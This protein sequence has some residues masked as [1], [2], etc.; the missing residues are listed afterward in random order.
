MERS[1]TGH[2][3]AAHPPGVLGLTRA[4]DLP[5]APVLATRDAGVTGMAFLELGSGEAASGV[6]AP[7]RDDAFLIALQ[8]RDCTDFDLYADGRLVRPR[9]FAAGNVAIFDLRENLAT[10]RRAAFH[11]VDLYLPQASL[12]AIAED[13]GAARIDDLRHDTG[14]AFRDAVARDLLSSIRPALALP[15]QANQLFLDHVALALASHV[16]HT[17]GG[18]RARPAT[19]PGALAPWQARRAQDLLAS[20]LGG[21]V[22]LAELAGACELSIRHFTR[23]FRATRLL[24][25]RVERAKALLADARR[26][27]GEVALDCGFADQSHFT[28]VFQQRVG[29]S[30]GA[31]RRLQRR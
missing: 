27:L 24:R 7:V 22:S 16:A 15:A 26:S 17:Y 13:A 8:L 31:W 3:T 30:P 25:L 23:A 1:A 19:Q 10:E 29:L 14:A 21:R 20:H 9:D 11:A 12:A 18:L 5:Q 4:M 6:A 28:R 2:E